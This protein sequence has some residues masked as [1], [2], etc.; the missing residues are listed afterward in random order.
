MRSGLP[1]F[2][3]RAGVA[4]IGA[5][6]RA[7]RLGAAGADEPGEAE[8]LAGAE[9]EVDL[10]EGA[11]APEI[12]D[13][14]HDVADLRVARRE[15]LRHRPADHQRDEIMG[16]RDRGRFEGRDPLAAAQDRDPVGDAADLVEPVRDEDD[17]GAFVAQ[18]PHDAQQRGGFLV[19]EGRRR[20]VHDQHRGAPNERAGDLDD[21]LLRRR[22]AACRPR[23]IDVE[24]AGE[25]AQHLRGLPLGLPPR[26]EDAAEARL[27]AEKHVLG[28][29]ELADDH[30]LLEDRDDAAAAGVARR[31]KARPACRRG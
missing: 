27:A 11:L 7:H 20:L 29:A 26:I 4:G 10:L 23:R 6:D 15:Q 3:T 28:D 13:L 30:Q 5:E 2:T 22:E 17:R 12:A 31:R 25:P 19:G 8:H 14:E 16:V 24:I 18:L 1:R 9:R 21:L